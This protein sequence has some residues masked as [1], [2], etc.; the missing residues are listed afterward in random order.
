MSKQYLIKHA[1]GAPGLRILGLGPNYLPCKGLKKLQLLL[2]KY[3]F[4]AKNRST[5]E[6][7]K[8]LKNSSLVISL[9]KDQKLIGFGRATTD[10]I[11]RAVIWD[12]VI[13]NDVQGNGYGRLIVKE[14]MKSPIIRNTKKIYLMT[15][16]RSEFYLQLGFKLNTKQKLLYINNE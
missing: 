14:L 12:V 5:S 16:N 11:F 1:P 15:T 10:G 3:T 8:M 2:D 4:W 9:W 6:L 13:A 7:R